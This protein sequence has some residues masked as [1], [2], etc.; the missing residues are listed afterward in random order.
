MGAGM[1][2]NDRLVKGAAVA[3]YMLV[4]V[5][6]LAGALHSL[7]DESA[8]SARLDFRVFYAAGLLMRHSPE[9]LYDVE[10]QI[11]TQRN[12]VAL[13]LTAPQDTLLPFV[14]P[15]IAAAPLAALTLLPPRPAYFVLCALNFILL[16][17]SVWLLSS[18]LGLSDDRKRMLALC[19]A[20]FLPIYAALFQGQFSLIVLFIYV[21]VITDIYTGR[22]SRAGAAAGLLVLKPT[23]LLAIP[24]WFLIRRQWSAL[25]WCGAVS[26]SLIAGSIALVGRNGITGYLQ[27]SR[28]LWA[29]DAAIG[30]ARSMPNLKAFT[31]FFGLGDAVWFVAVAVMLVTLA[32]FRRPDAETCSGLLIA[33]V[34]ISPHFHIHDLAIVIIPV[35]FALSRMERPGVYWLL[36]FLLQLPLLF[37]S[38]VPLT[39]WPILPAALVVVFIYCAVKARSSV[40]EAVSA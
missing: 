24:L 15:A 10:S 21:L 19:T 22:M 11:Q 39:Q 2:K 32:L 20:S 12:L 3:I 40:L 26:G 29:N 25:L 7:M 14:Y 23:L 16:A 4:A 6:L 33:G 13:G 36:L 27:L 1:R 35:A 5:A 18:R 31:E 30:L 38:G 9:R 28:L 37:T 34:L 17:A 8:W